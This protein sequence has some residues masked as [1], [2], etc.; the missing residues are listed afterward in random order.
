MVAH[1][2]TDMGGLRDRALV[3]LGMAGAF[4]RSELVALNVS[5]LTFTDHGVDVFLR[6]SK[7]DQEGEG[8]TVAVP[9]GKSLH[10]VAAVTVWIEAAKLDGDVPLFCPVNKGGAVSSERLTGW[11]VAKIVKSYAALAGLDATD[12]SGHSLRAGFV[13]SAADRG[14]DMQRIMDQTRHKDPRTV[15]GYIRRSERYRDHAG[16]GFL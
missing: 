12:F 2:A 3:L 9:N 6:R 4:R 8:Y 7:T 15:R 16:S 13:T 5:D 1:M 10:P 14:A 11:S